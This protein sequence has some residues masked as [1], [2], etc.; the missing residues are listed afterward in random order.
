MPSADS[1]ERLLE[2][3]QLRHPAVSALLELDIACQ[4]PAAVIAL[5]DAKRAGRKTK[6]KKKS[7]VYKLVPASDNDTAIVAKRCR[8][9]SGKIERFIYDQILPQLPV[10]SPTYHGSVEIDG[11]LWLFLDYA[12]GVEWDIDN[13]THLDLAIHW[14]SNMH[15]SSAQL[16]LLSQ[17]PDRGPHYYQSQ[18]DKASQRLIQAHS[19]PDLQPSDVEILNGFIKQT[20]LLSSR[21]AEIQQFC[22]SMPASLIHND[23]ISKNLHVCDLKSGPVLL[24]FDW[25]MSGKGMPAT[26]LSW[27]FVK[28]PEGTIAKH[29]K[30]MRLFNPNIDLCDIEYMAAVGTVFRISDAVEWASHDLLTEYPRRKISHFE[31]YTNRLA[32]VS[33]A[34]GWT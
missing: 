18:L 6:L 28:A 22:Q 21:W 30:Q 27:M 13:E 19:N 14:L 26:D 24:P 29:H 34:L 31:K 5:Y 7:A 16:E 11:A 3:S 9:A 8:T 33:V 20:E 12:D 10:S 1:N 17:L 15:G 4:E 23:F 2:E 25:E 32:R